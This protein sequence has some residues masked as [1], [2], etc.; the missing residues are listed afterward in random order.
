MYQKSY[1]VYNNNRLSFQSEDLL[2]EREQL[3]I[4]KAQ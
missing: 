1:C 4:K 3:K 2:I